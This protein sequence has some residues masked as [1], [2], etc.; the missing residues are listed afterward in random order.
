MMNTAAQAATALRGRVASGSDR[1]GI[2][3]TPA[4][5]QDRKGTSGSKRSVGGKRNKRSV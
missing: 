5:S 2:R 1:P 4:K 3:A